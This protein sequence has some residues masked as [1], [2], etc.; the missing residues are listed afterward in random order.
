VAQPQKS[1][2][3]QTLPSPLPGAARFRIDLDALPTPSDS[4]FASA[5][6]VFDCGLFFEFA[7]TH[8]RHREKPRLVLTVVVNTDAVINNL[9]VSAQQFY[10][11]DRRIFQD[12]RLEIPTVQSSAPADEQAPILA[13]N[14]FRMARTGVE[15][16]LECYYVPPYEIFRA[17]H[18]GTNPDVESVVRIQLPGPVLTGILDFVAAKVETLRGR[19]GKLASTAEVVQQ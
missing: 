4:V 6:A 19:L 12:A 18:K 14:L 5:C 1:V 10:E 2:P 8:A 15:T 3:F 7:F 17:A 11:T 16:A 13:S 9:W